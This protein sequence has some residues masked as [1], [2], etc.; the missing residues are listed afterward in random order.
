MKRTNVTICFA[1][2]L[3]CWA[4]AEAPVFTGKVVA[5]SDGDTISVMHGGKPEKIRL[6]G[7]DS[8]ESGQPFGNRAKEFSS[9]LSFGQQVAVRVKDM[10]RYGRTVAEVVLPDGRILNHE[11]VS[12]GFA[13]WYQ[14]YAPENKELR[15]LEKL[16]REAKV[17]LWADPNPIAPWEFRN[18][19]I[20]KTVPAPL[21]QSLGAAA[22]SAETLATSANSLVYV[23]TTGKKYHAD[24]CR[25]LSKS[26]I[27]LSLEDAKTNGYTPCSVC[28]P[29]GGS[30]ENA[31]ALFPATTSTATQAIAL[32]TSQVYITKSGA[33]YHAAGCR[34]LSKSQ[35]PIALENAKAR[36]YL[37]CSV[38]RPAD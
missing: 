13:W 16:A 24:G 2:A 33:K 32:R 12:A 3:C 29:T 21:P 19:G 35:I 20:P 30:S 8:P 26:K 17:G 38:C 14:Q 37:P 4:F 15:D 5:V 1:L 27:P 22:T 34:Y 9:S 18:G 23:T 36:G 10:D 7:I 6:H 31:P 11:M 25:Y 28:K